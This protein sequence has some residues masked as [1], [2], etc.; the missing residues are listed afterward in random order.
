MITFVRKNMAYLSGE[1]WDGRGG[2]W[3]VRRPIG[4]DQVI[5][6]ANLEP[7]PLVRRGETVRLVYEG[8]NI[9]LETLAE[10]MEDGGAGQA[11]AV[12][13]LESERQVTA[14]VRDSGTVY[15]R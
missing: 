1:V 11:I 13:N 7:L 9:R 2:P 6:A 10:A 3:Q 15:V 12:K 14:T 5:Y 8:K 4:L